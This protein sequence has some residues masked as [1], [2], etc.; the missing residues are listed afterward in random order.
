[1]PH[2]SDILISVV[3]V[4]YKVPES[5]RQA[6]L[7]LREA[8]LYP[9]TE[10]I[11][12]DNAS[13]DGSKD[14]AAREFP[15]VKWIQ[16][17]TNIGFGKAC[18]VGARNAGG[19]YLLVLNPDTIIARTTLSLAYD[20]LR[21]HP[22]VGVVGP[23]LLNPDGTLQPGCRRGFPTPQAALYRL[24]GLSRLF[25]K[26]KRF[27]H[28][29]LT[30]LDPDV[31]YEV[32]AVSG[33][34]MFLPRRLFESIGGFDEQFFMYG[35]DLD[36]CRRIK[37]KGYKVWYNPEMRVIHLKGKSSAKRLLRSRI[38]FYQ[39]MVLFSK[40]YQHSH[41]AFFP[42]WLIFVGITI[43]A[44][45]N[46]GS[47]LLQAFTASI[48]DLAIINIALGVSLTVRLSHPEAASPYDA[49]HLM[50]MIGV[51]ALLS[52]SFLSMFAY[53]GIY[54]QKKYS[55]ANLLLSGFFASVVFLA[56][57]YCIK[58][59]AYSRLAFAGASI[60][61]ILLLVGWR[62]ILPKMLHSLKRVVYRRDRVIIAGSGPIPL[63]V[64]Q[65][66]EKQKAA[67]IVGILWTGD[68]ELPGQFEG[69]PVL[70][71]IEDVAEVLQRL[72]VDML[73]IAT[74]L[75]WYSFIIEALSKIKAKN[76]TIRWVPRELFEKKDEELPAVIPLKDFSV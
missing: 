22:E 36:L 57:V 47:K 14:M 40:K 38:A 56:C 63:T 51:H 60:I 27:G 61:I 10:V 50:T 34:F 9:Q 26:S 45:M 73:V 41:G 7:S 17:K 28:Y 55:A 35:E 29:N 74:A 11:I 65:N 6:L 32:D 68:A 4:N 70:G 67:T 72:R 2:R 39:A 54:S 23:K 44:A 21:N 66:I 1:L 3:I 48:I 52:I 33:S 46:I 58:S 16:L 62:E 64:I 8:D 76:L 37:E 42:R 20:F 18:N 19:D 15:E 30:Y 5:L 13:H 43:Q 69:Y 75:P 24:S 25:P 53:N 12:V 71:R 59:I 49:E 31:S